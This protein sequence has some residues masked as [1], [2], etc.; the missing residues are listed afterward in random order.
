MKALLLLLALIVPSGP[1]GDVTFD[2]SDMSTV[3]GE[4]FTL[5][6]RVT[7][8]TDGLLAHLNVVSLTSDVYVDPEDWSANRTQRAAPV[9][10]WDIQAVNAGTFDVY[11]VLLPSTGRGPLVV[12]P[13]VHLTVAG[14]RTFTA[15]G[16]LPVAL[17]V[18]VLL[19]LLAAAGQYRL[20]VR[21][22]RARGG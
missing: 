22:G 14:R 1:V 19:G 21:L 9:L 11:V 20:R 18:P 3:V 5:R 12:S 13:P 6:S 17:A 2:H 4:R 16:A 10:S 15:G 8:P 7:G